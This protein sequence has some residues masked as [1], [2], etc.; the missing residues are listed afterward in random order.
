ML[1]KKYGNAL[2]LK[3]TYP[4]YFNG[5]ELF[6]QAYSFKGGGSYKVWIYYA[7]G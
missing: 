1:I 4:Q 5:P 7:E 6:E 2:Q 3:I